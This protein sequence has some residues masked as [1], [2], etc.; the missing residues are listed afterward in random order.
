MLP[1][2]CRKAAAGG[3][4]GEDTRGVGCRMDRVAAQVP[5][6]SKPLLPPHEAV[7]G[8]STGAGLETLLS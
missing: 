6:S 8:V 3:G 1:K 7:S 4:K 2:P 5:L